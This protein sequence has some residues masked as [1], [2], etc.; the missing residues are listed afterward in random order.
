[1]SEHTPVR[2]LDVIS[3]NT[4]AII[5]SVSERLA[6]VK[7]RAAAG[8]TAEG[9]MNGNFWKLAAAVASGKF[10]YVGKGLY[11]EANTDTDYGRIWLKKEFKNPETGA[12]EE[13]LVAYTTDED[14]IVRQLATA[15]KKAALQTTAVG[16]KMPDPKN[17]PLA[18]GIKS[19]NITMDE[20][21]GGGT[22]K[23]TVEFSDVDQGLKFYQDGIQSGAPAKKEE[24][25]EAP[26]A[27]EGEAGEGAPAPA[28]AA[29]GPGAGGPPVPPVPGGGATPAGLVQP[30]SREDQINTLIKQS[31]A[32]PGWEGAVKDMKKEYGE[33]S[34][35]PFATAWKLH[36]EGRKPWNQKKKRKSSIEQFTH[37]GQKI[38]TV[39]RYHYAGLDNLTV[40]TYINESGETC[41]LPFDFHVPI[42]GQF[43]RSD[44]G[45]TIR[46][47]GYADIT[48]EPLESI[49]SLLAEE[50]IE[51][52]GKLYYCTTCGR[53][54]SQGQ[55]NFHKGHNT[56]EDADAAPSDAASS[57][58]A[59]KEASQKVAVHN[60]VKVAPTIKPENELF[61][62]YPG[63]TLT[64]ERPVLPSEDP[65]DDLGG[66]NS[67]DMAG[68]G[69]ETLVR[70]LMGENG[71]GAGS[72]VGN[73]H[74]IS[75]RKY[76]NSIGLREKSR[77]P[78]TA[79]DVSDQVPPMGWE[80]KGNAGQ[81]QGAGNAMPPNPALQQDQGTQDASGNAVLYDSQKDDGPQFQTT[82]NP[83][84]KSVTVKF[85]DSPEE[86]A[87]NK[88]LTPQAPPAAGGATPPAAT[89]PAPAAPGGPAQPAQFGQQ[90][91]P[92]EF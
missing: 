15:T 68:V 74:G 84:D 13:W 48:F 82:I 90:N 65:Y 58:A 33:D 24:K 36:G 5:T 81:P 30:A 17:V 71:G 21:G 62:E 32:P 35:K 19:K 41:P 78:K 49:A 70:E 80:G 43:D 54:Y 88:A 25:P 7:Q 14:E 12:M 9:L 40:Y 92:V 47:A 11:K 57:D 39:Q 26:A 31:V 89:P 66:S 85:V 55:S 79:A 56:R 22:A 38:A 16:E 61:T 64:K 8:P 23:V 75:V 60:P 76:P 20:T 2:R 4:S 50:S 3:K 51:M 73:P 37:R 63:S 45:A 10:Q 34:S 29:G 42:G 18:Q 44:T 69:D 6:Q 46:L 52:T 91:V 87:L 1:M 27:D 72:A 83:K 53:K 77:Y 59:T 67:D 28:P 86:Q